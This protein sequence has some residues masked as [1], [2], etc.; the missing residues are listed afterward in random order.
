M[1]LLL[2]LA[3][4]AVSGNNSSLSPKAHTLSLSCSLFRSLSL[5]LSL[6]LHLSPLSLSLSLI[7]SNITWVELYSSAVLGL[8]PLFRSVFFGSSCLSQM[9]LMIFL[10]LSFSLSIS[11]FRALRCPLPP[12]EGFYPC[13]GLAFVS[14]KF[15]WCHNLW[16]FARKN[17]R[18]YR[19]PFVCMCVCALVCVCLCVSSVHWRFYLCICVLFLLVRLRRKERFHP[20]SISYTETS[21][22]PFVR[23][24]FL[25]SPLAG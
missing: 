2:P 14:L 15:S 5:S 7:F 25:F 12:T 18:T 10:S 9:V 4:P 1:F 22:K 3:P 11:L 24:Q 16:P 8:F 19:E 13:P 23:K 20:S 21:N 17:L 6:S